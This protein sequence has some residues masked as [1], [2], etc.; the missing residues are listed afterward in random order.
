M[1]LNGYQWAALAAG[2]ITP[3]A[4][5]LLKKFIVSDLTKQQKNLKAFLLMIQYSEG[6]AGKNAY[7]MLYGGQFFNDFSRHPNIAV[8][9]W[10]LTSTAAGAYQ[11]LFRTWQ[12]L[13]QKLNLTD[14]GPQNQDRAAIELIRQK[15]ALDDVLAGRFVQAIDKCKKVW[16]SLP[17]AGYGQ[18]EKNATGLLAV[19]KMA[20]GSVAA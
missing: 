20:G 19:Y 8:S 18:H 6:T 15:K 1:K 16:A 3:A 12:E 13:Q 2:L 7:K 17:G 14:F 9:K 10:G 11:I 4:F 5:F